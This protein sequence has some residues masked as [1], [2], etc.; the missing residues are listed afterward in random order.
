VLET[1]LPAPGFFTSKI[2]I[3]T[4]GIVGPGHDFI[5]SIV[6]WFGE[7]FA[8]LRE[9]NPLRYT[10]PLVPMVHYRFIIC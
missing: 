3:H 4:G 1:Y 2:G 8:Y 10:P 7:P 6:R 9:D 5:D